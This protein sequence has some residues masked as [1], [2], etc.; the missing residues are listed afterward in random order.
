M[1]GPAGGSGPPGGGFAWAVVFACFVVAVFGWGFGF[2][3]QAVYLA[4]LHRTRG[5][6]A[7]LISSATTVYYLFG[8]VL[9]A[10]VHDA[11]TRLGSRL[12]MLGGAALL[13]LGATAVGLAT[14]PWQLYA[15]SLVMAFGWAATSSTAITTTIAL[16]FDARRG[17]AISLASN[18]A[19]AAGFTVAP[20]LVYLSSRY[21]LAASV[22]GVAGALWLLLLPTILF[23][24]R[25]PRAGAAD[26]HAAGAAATVPHVAA[27]R[28]DVLRSLGFWTIAGPFAL[29]LAAQ[30]GYLTHQVAFLLPTLGAERTGLAIAYGSIAAMSG[31]VGL[32]LVVDRLN[33]RIVTAVSLLSQALALAAMVSWHGNATVL[34]LG[35]ILFGLSVGNVITLPALIVQREFDARSFGMVI[36]LSTA[37]GQV[38]YAFGPALLGVIRD[39]V[40]SYGAALGLCMTLEVV[41]A[42]AVLGGPAI[43]RIAR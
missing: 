12:V 42:L 7:S 39:A 38:T 36:G 41:A 27:R 25:R 1:S 14:Q 4:E 26:T 33:Q 23:G 32:G 30:V 15:A 3:G 17:L 13:G 8:A 43:G 5:W 2:Y 40:G 18:G 22:A 28:Q 34:F 35:S 31:R 19:S 9:L 37:I 21:G 6:S 11:I 16:W 29:A 24:L 10:L 20:M